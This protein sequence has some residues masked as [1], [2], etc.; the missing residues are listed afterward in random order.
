[1][2]P[3]LS[4][5]HKILIIQYQPFGD[6]LLN[7]GYFPTLREKFP[8]A[9]IDFLVR[10]P[11]HHALLE[12]PYL[13]NLLIF[14]NSNGLNYFLNRIKLIKN[15]RS[16]HYD[17]V[18]DQIRN[19]GSAQFT[20]FSGARY[21]LGL[22]NQR[23]RSFYNL[24]A[25][26]KSI[27]YYS[28]MKFDTLAPLGINEVAHK[29]Y[30]KIKDES[31]DFINNWLDEHQSTD[32]KWVCLSPGSPVRS[33]KWAALNYAKLADKITESSDY[34]ILLIWGPGEKEDV[35]KVLGLINKEAVIAPKTT[36]NQA[37]AL[38]KKCSL[39]ICNDGGINHL[40]V[41]TETPSIAFF[42]RHKPTRWSPLIFN[43]HFHFYKENVDYKNDRTLGI[44]VD[45]VFEKVKEVLNI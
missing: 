32:S 24:K 9:E 39:L 18:I 19:T 28:A 2:T 31:V 1:M 23:W 17:L 4:K 29:L 13:D 37:A 12:N 41:A 36:F 8:T 45:E 7:T 16:R 21:R 22:R 25:E 42:G 14:K 40:S 15:I 10:E 3:D 26:R 5:I 35:E 33:K 30:L 20:I 11:Y 6:V 27:R 44:S 34:R 43:N 38:L